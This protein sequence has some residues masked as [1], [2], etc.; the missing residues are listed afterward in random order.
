MLDLPT[1]G[2]P[3]ITYDTLLPLILISAA[4]SLWS[5]VSAFMLSMLYPLELSD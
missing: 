1:P 5:T 2:S 4:A 3:S